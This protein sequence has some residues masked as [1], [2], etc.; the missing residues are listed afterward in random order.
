MTE[1]SVNLSGQPARVLRSAAL[2][3]LVTG[4]TSAV[5]LTLYAGRQNRSVVLVGLFA[6]WVLSPFLGLAAA[7][8]LLSKRS[9]GSMCM[10]LHAIT[11]CIA[12]GSVAVYGFVAL[13]PP[14]PQ[15]AFY[16]LVTPLLSWFAAGATVA[17]AVVVSRGDAR[18]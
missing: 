8:R 6:V 10:A 12:I 18:A 4:A 11:L 13:G 17:L 9:S 1:S 7:Q 15:M 16:F 2:I 3:A 14:V 5:V